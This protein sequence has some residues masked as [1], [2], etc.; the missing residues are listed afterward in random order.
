[1]RKWGIVIALALAA[2]TATN[3]WAASTNRVSYPAECTKA[4][5]ID[6]HLNNL[7]ARITRLETWKA[8]VQECLV[9]ENLTTHAYL[10][11]DNTW[12]N[13]IQ[14]TQQGENVSYQMI[15]NKFGNPDCSPS[16]F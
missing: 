6:K 16:V 12:A 5:C 4:P 14:P 13:L 3:V 15:H 7:D 11:N 2:L 1:M 8:R 9:H 10:M